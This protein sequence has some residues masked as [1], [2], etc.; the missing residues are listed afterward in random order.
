[1]KVNLYF[2]DD[3][4]DP[5]AHPHAPAGS[6]KGG[7]FVKKGSAPLAAQ[8]TF[9]QFQGHIRKLNSI[10]N[11]TDISDEEAGAKIKSYMSGLKSYK[12]VDYANKLLGHLDQG[13][14]GEG[15]APAGEKKA[16]PEKAAPEKAPEKK[17]FPKKPFTSVATVKA[18]LNHI[19]QMGEYGNKPAL[20]FAIEHSSSSLAINYAK[21]MLEALGGPEKP[22]KVTILPQPHEGSPHQ[23]ALYD[24]AQSGKDAIE[25]AAAILDT[26]APGTYSQN[27]KNELLKAVGYEVP[28][29]PA[30][31]KP[32]SPSTNKFT[33]QRPADQKLLK[34]HQEAYDYSN[35]SHVQG[36]VEAIPT[37]HETSFNA[38]TAKQRSALKS[39]TGSGYDSINKVLRNPKNAD[40]DTVAKINLIDDAFEEDV[41]KLTH[42]IVVRRGTSM[43]ASTMD[44]SNEALANIK[45]GLKSGLP[46]KFS[47][48]G[49]ISTSIASGFGGEIKM[50]ILLRKGT[51]ALYVGAIS[52]HEHEKELLLR[53]GQQFRVLE[54]EEKKNGEHVL[55]MVAEI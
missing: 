45:A 50:N 54:Y 36:V 20:Q 10:A 14:I 41:A 43:L 32:A 2:H 16:A 4:Y 6:A 53:H 23:K 55:T 46:V 37:F 34:A 48:R 5:A 21:E 19:E 3:A 11:N 35:D 30:A 8:S 25:Q 7:Q 17:A 39:Y 26:N 18:K 27:Y 33:S 31:T 28:E 29:E 40:P 44:K 12:L 24:A 52:S 13:K 38:F 42:D 47:Q 51:P 1:M 49:F 9:K 15:E 22:P